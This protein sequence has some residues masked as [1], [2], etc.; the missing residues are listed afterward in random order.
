M[1][2][3][4]IL[5]EKCECGRHINYFELHQQYLKNNINKDKRIL[6]ISSVVLV[7]AIILIF[8]TYVYMIQQPMNAEDY[9]IVGLFCGSY[10]TMY[11]LYFIS[12]F[13]TY[14]KNNSYN[15]KKKAK[16][17]KKSLIRKK[18]ISQL[19]KRQHNKLK[20]LYIILIS[21]IIII[22]IPVYIFIN[23][24]LDL[25]FNSEP[26]SGLFLYLIFILCLIGIGII[27]NKPSKKNK[28][29]I[30]IKKYVKQYSINHNLNY[31][32]LFGIKKGD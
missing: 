19:S 32:I 3:K 20:Q 1:T 28:M 17:Y 29:S 14:N 21:V 6:I 27:T 11:I 2:N 25:T 4:N 31:T 16:Q 30:S 13:D 23:W 22:M 10:L 18:Y 5:N 24:Y 26:N 7:I 15:A 9:L 12:S 8:I